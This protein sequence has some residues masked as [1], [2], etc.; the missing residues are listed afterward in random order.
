MRFLLIAGVVF[1]TGLAAPARGAVLARD[2]AVA[3]P[4]FD[5]TG[6]TWIVHHDRGLSV[7]TW[8]NGRVRER[9]RLPGKHRGVA[10]FPRTLAASPTWLAFEAITGNRAALWAS[11]AGGRLAV[12]HRAWTS[13]AADG[14]AL[15]WLE[16]DGE[17]DTIVLRDDPMRRRFAAGRTGIDDA[18]ITGILLA[19]PYVGWFRDDRGLTVVER[20]G[21]KQVLNVRGYV[22][23]A[24]LRPD[25]TV[26]AVYGPK[27]DGRRDVVWTSP[28]SPSPTVVVRDAGSESIG[29]A[30]D[31]I[32][33]RPYDDLE[34]ALAVVPLGG[35][36][37][38]ELFRHREA[39]KHGIH[40]FAFDGSR[41]V[42]AE[43]DDVIGEGSGTGSV[44]MLDVP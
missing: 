7:R 37:P 38:R 27:V 24:A 33:Y 22:D 34:Y 16:S 35:G 39:G 9:A 42:W 15:A 19:G 8:R 36:P 25:G 41:V 21:G 1:L 20:A 10:Y 3:G 4:V 32:V 28:A 23:T 29:F 43:E 2:F 11:R 18:G 5:G 14:P 40:A 13:V 31:R 12:R 17:Q 30:G 26:A 44:R 6:V